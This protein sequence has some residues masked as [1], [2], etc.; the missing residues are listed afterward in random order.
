MGADDQLVPR[1][2]A[3]YR[4]FVRLYRI[5]RTLRPTT[6]DRWNGELLATQDEL[7]GSVSP[8]TGAVRLSAQHVMPYLTGSTSHRHPAEQAEALATVLHETT[9]TAME[10]KGSAEP[11][12]VYSAHSRGLM[13]GVAELR[14]IQDFD[15]FI[16][17]AGYPDLALPQPH[18]KGAYAA[19]ASL[20]NQ[21]AGPYQDRRTLMNE[22][23]AGPV[24]LHFDRLAAAVV[25]NRLWDVVPYQPDHQHAVRAA[26]IRP[27]LHEVWPD[28]PEH[29]TSTG[30]RVADEI[31]MDLNAK[32]DEIQRHYRQ[33]STEP[34]TSTG[35][36]SHSA[37][38]ERRTSHPEYS[39]SRPPDELRFLN[40]L[41][42]A[43]LA[44][45]HKPLLANGSHTARSPVGRERPASPRTS[46]SENERE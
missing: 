39:I 31:R 26:L 4:E 2:S 41:A 37:A 30:E 13:E 7:W 44:T 33:G 19:T 20:L 10:M 28:L 45:R 36:P 3:A 25:R 27:M 6:V 43:A 34:F 46:P 38:S 23:I 24:V 12:A 18:Y 15:A 40:G 8:T 42:P 9:H 29:S 22:L 35:A 5:A 17:R 21:A 16:V 14:A 11:N 1:E 32:V